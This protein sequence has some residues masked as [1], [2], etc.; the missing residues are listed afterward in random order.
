MLISFRGRGRDVKQRKRDVSELI[1]VR[2]FSS[3]LSS[4]TQTKS[5]WVN[6]T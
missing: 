3:R 6:E 5:G 1:L 2:P 4:F